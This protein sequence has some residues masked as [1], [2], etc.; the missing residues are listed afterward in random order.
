MV[1]LRLANALHDVV[2]GCERCGGLLAV[3]HDGFPDCGYEP[4]CPRVATS[5]A[6]SDTAFG[7]LTMP[8]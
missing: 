1:D 5:S 2:D 7:T 3:D 4:A 6:I 8:M